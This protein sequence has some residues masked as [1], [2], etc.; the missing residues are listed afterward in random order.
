MKP[1][2]S[3]T[4]PDRAHERTGAWG[5]VAD[6]LAKIFLTPSDRAFVDNL[7]REETTVLF[8]EL[9]EIF[10]C[11]D[12]TGAMLGIVSAGEASDVTRVLERSYTD[13]FEGI[14][15][16]TTV[17]L[18]E[19]AYYGDGHRLFQEPLSEMNAT[20]QRLDIAIDGGCAEPAD[21]LAIELAALAYALKCGD[22]EEAA[23]LIARLRTWA[24]V[25]SGRLQTRDQIGFYAAA[26]RLLIAY[27]S[28]M[29]ETIAIAARAETTVTH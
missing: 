2:T 23:G 1:V 24:P 13:L 3:Q 4:S 22:T 18:Y 6:W 21:H 11:R 20:L 29:S 26:A 19:S 5:S 16:P 27:L 15:G 12:A 25:L 9:G 10:E 7:R 28:A 14:S 8:V 17:L